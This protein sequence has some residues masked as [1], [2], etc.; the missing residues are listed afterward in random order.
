MW[1][2]TTS[3]DDGTDR[4]SVRAARLVTIAATVLFTLLV[5]RWRPWDLFAP[6]GFSTDF[7]DE[8]ARAFLHGR[9]AVRPSVA[10]PEG[11]LIDGRTYLYYGP[12]LAVVRLPF[13]LFGD[14]FT[15]RLTRMSLIV[16]YVAFCTGSFHL[17]ERAR[18]WAFGRWHLPVA[19]VSSPWRTGLFVAAAACS[20]MLFLTGWVSVYHETEL[21]AAT[22]ALWSAVSVLRLIDA[23]S[24]RTAIITAAFIVAAILTRAPVGLGAAGGAGLIALTQWKRD[25]GG[26]IIVLGGCIAGFVVH[27]A[28]NWAKFGSPTALPADQQLLSIQDPARAAWFAGNHGSFFSV[29]FL[30]T[31]LVQYLRPDTVRFERLIP[32]VRFG[33]L[34]TDRGSYPVESITPT[35]SLP[36]TASLL[37]VAAVIGAV[38][39]VRQR[40]LVWLALIAGAAIAAV[41]TFTIGFVANR[42]L[43]DMVPLLLIPAAVAF[44]ALALPNTSLRQRQRQWLRALALA[45]IAWGAW[46]NAA[47][48]TWTQNLKE[49]GFTEL[50]YRLDDVAFGDPAPSLVV[51]DQTGPVPRDGVVGL[52]LRA[53]GQRCE[54]VY[55]AEQG[56]WVNLERLDGERQ[57]TGVV[58]LQPG[59]IVPIAGGDTWLA[60]L[61]VETQTMHVVVDDNGTIATG[62]ALDFQPGTATLRVVNDEI[63]GQFS[64]TLLGDA[65]APAF[66]RF[67]PLPGPMLAYSDVHVQAVTPRDETL[68]HRL[69]DRL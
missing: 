3:P 7:Y 14:M 50:R 11:F 17:L 9:L 2:T 15:A 35:S 34:A 62:Q 21:W 65:P 57:L 40:D 22:F 48:A 61:V 12:L 53:D 46:C 39:I 33:P 58:D 44:A 64:V 19:A 24:R 29:R 54:A 31:T 20:P 30:P 38:M 41:P 36:T 63:A 8:Q 10:G 26:S 5:C 47:L 16:G 52:A 1:R 66:F 69:E 25:R 23:P 60:S 13:A 49:P 68:C 28:I 37:C 59:S 4:A 67:G 18:R 32:F 6:A 56:V 43:V 55:I 42:Y 45:A 27:S 51:I